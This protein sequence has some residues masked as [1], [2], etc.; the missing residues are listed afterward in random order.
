[1][2][3]ENNKKAVPYGI[4]VKEEMETNETAGIKIICFSIYNSFFPNFIMQSFI[5]IFIRIF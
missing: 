3:F 2:N 4:V 5:K 1:M